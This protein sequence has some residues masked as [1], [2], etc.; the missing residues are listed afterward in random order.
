V[1]RK[2]G[3]MV[4]K[5]EE[6]HMGYDRMKTFYENREQSLR[7]EIANLK[8]KVGEAELRHDYLESKVLECEDQIEHQRL[9]LREFHEKE[10]QCGIRKLSL[11]AHCNTM[12]KLV[13]EAAVT[14]TY[15]MHHL[16]HYIKSTEYLQDKVNRISQA[17]IDADRK[18]VQEIGKVQ[19]IPLPGMRKKPRRQPFHIEATKLNFKACP[20]EGYSEVPRTEMLDYALTYVARIHHSKDELRAMEGTPEAST[21]GPS[22]PPAT[23]GQE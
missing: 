11:E 6:E 20:T 23:P 5:L 19:D 4:S 17:W 14:T 22:T 3:E 21:S 1:E 15:N 13:V 8:D 2:E 10:K 16:V 9:T 7:K 12:E 18:R